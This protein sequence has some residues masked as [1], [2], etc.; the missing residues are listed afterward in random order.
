MT[1][2]LTMR[3]VAVVLYAFVALCAVPVAVLVAVAL[4]YKPLEVVD[5]AALEGFADAV[6]PRA[7]PAGYIT[8]EQ[9]LKLSRNGMSYTGPFDQKFYD[10]NGNFVNE[11]TGEMYAERYTGN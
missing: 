2:A 8:L 10:V 5:P 7:Y 6:R 4:T 11:I 3:I 9:S 1:A